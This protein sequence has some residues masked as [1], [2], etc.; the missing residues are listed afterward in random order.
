MH[1]G[2]LLMLLAH[3]CSCLAPGV[4]VKFAREGKESLAFWLAL[5]GK[6]DY[7]SKK[8]TQ[9]IVRE[10][11]LFAIQSNKGKFEI[12]EVYSFEQ[13]DLLTEDVMI[14]DTHAEVIVWV[15]QSVDPKEKQNALATGQKY[16]D[17]AASAEGLCPH[18]PLFR[19]PEGSE[20][21]FFTA[22][23]SWDH[24]K[25][26]VQG[27][28]FTK[29]AMQLF[30]P[31]CTTESQ[32]NKPQGNKS[33]GATQRA[34]AMAALTSAFNSSSQTKTP[35]APRI[36]TRG[37]QRA[38]AVAA[39]SAVLTAEKKAPA[40][41]PGSPRKHYKSNTSSEP[42]SPLASAGSRT[43]GK[44]P[45]KN[46]EPSNVISASPV[47]NE[48]PSDII[49]PMKN[50]EPS[51]TI[52]NS[53][54]SEVADGTSEPNV[55]TNEEDSSTKEADENENSGEEIQSSYT[56]DQ[57]R[58]KSDNPVTGIDFKKRES[59]LS[60]E[61]FEEIFKMTKE[62]FYNFPRWKQDQIKKKV[63]LF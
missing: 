9:E 8:L 20:P 35:I 29:K 21:C 6:Q 25:T 17:V 55:E 30:G 26:T 49:S 36:F 39:L 60:P 37:S 7:T 1:F 41:E 54:V 53:E 5:G 61:E 11:H 22:Y 58:S 59:Y 62:T 19:V 51:D 3:R 40:S 34:S 46:E 52:D 32:D 15:G 38:A 12:E 18:V 4:P 13:D 16:I 43:F 42:V 44:S 2:D 24:A 45:V 47:K 31:G 28:S 48:E 10:P 14:L 56:Y 63:D 23:F 50:E 57:L 33:S 27:N